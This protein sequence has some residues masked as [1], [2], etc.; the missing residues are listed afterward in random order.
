MAQ[1]GTL[2]IDMGSTTT[3]VAFQAGDG[4]PGRLLEIP[5]QLQ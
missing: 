4:T 3:V 2:A 5:L 1:D